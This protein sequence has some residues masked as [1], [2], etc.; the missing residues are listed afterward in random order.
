MIDADSPDF[1][2]SF[3]RGLAVIRAFGPGARRLTLTEVAE[4]TDMTRAA[5]RR[6]LLTLVALGYARSDGKYFELTP[7]VMEIGYAYLSSIDLWE[8]LQPDLA[9][10]TEKLHESCSASVL[11]GTE[12][13]Y[14][15]RSASRHRVIS[16][17]LSVGSRLPAHATA[18]GQV[19]LAALGEDGLDAYLA[20]AVLARFTEKTVSDA[21]AL[22]ARLE[23]V[24]HQGYA[25]ADQELEY[26]LRSL[27]VPLRGRDGAALAAMNVSVHAGRVGAE[28]LAASYLP[29]LRAAAAHCE[30]ALALHPGAQMPPISRVS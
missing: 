4:R 9:D 21:A 18:M 17:G 14:V 3:A 20:E 26:G 30:R 12:I 23:T 10:V 28:T 6:F 29:V 11:D 1:V 13:V 22:R 25:I 24:A 19:L 15:A 27:A 5:A 7:S 16:I 8:A 2:T